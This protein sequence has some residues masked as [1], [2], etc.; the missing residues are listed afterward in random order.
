MLLELWFLLSH[1]SGTTRYET[2]SVRQRRHW[3]LLYLLLVA[4][5][6]C[7]ST[8]LL[9]VNLKSILKIPMNL[10][11]IFHSML[12]IIL[13]ETLFS[14]QLCRYITYNIT[15]CKCNFISKTL[16]HIQ[17][18][19]RSHHFYFHSLYQKLILT[20]DINEFCISF[21]TIVDK[22]TDQK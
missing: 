10:I 21:Q 13:K 17:G 11:F 9:S 4:E 14:D 18:K 2:S 20:K 19:E 5:K 16:F 1:V 7:C 22:H 8:S 12:E 6:K 3:K 15:L